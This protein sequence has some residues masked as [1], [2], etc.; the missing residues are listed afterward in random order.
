VIGVDAYRTDSYPATARPAGAGRNS[1]RLPASAAV[2]LRL[3]KFF[4]L[5]RGG[6]V[7]VVVEAFNLLNR[8]NVTERNMVFGSG[9]T[10]VAGFG[11]PLEAGP[12]RQIEFSLD[13]E[14]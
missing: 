7:D 2:N 8:R 1:Q 3:L 11:P 12:A 5:H 6:R 10:A 4:P 13:Y 9:A 14:F